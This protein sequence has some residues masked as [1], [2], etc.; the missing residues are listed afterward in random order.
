[1]QTFL[2]LPWLCYNGAHSYRSFLWSY[3]FAETKENLFL[4]KSL[5]ISPE[6]L[7]RYKSGLAV[8]E[9]SQSC[10]LPHSVAPGFMR[11]RDELDQGTDVAENCDWFTWI[12][13]PAQGR[14]R[15]RVLGGHRAFLV[16]CALMLV[17]SEYVILSSLSGR[18]P[19]FVSAPWGGLLACLHAFDKNIV[20]GLLLLADMKFSR[21]PSKTT[22]D[23]SK[24]K[25]VI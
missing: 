16:L 15:Q 19:C 3:I 10:V 21:T 1:M 4:S 9:K 14:S 18:C 12:L 7:S 23:C 8:K 11:P 20:C 13:E 5:G 24:Y 17:W 2:V 25:L 6:I 22:Q